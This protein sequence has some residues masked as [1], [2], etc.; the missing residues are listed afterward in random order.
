MSTGPRYRRRVDNNHAEI[1]ELF[2][3]CGCKVVDTSN[4]GGK[5]GDL[6][7]QYRD[8]STKNYQL[9]THVI[10]TKATKKSKLTK[11]QKDNALTLIRIDCRADVFSLLGQSDW[12]LI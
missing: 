3:D 1:R 12:E 8:P 9:F 4:L 11:S 10:E 2:R 7:I 5:V 6:L